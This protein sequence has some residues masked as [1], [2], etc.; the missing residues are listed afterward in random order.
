MNKSKNFSICL[1]TTGEQKKKEKKVG[2]ILLYK[3][4]ITNDLPILN[5][6]T[7]I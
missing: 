6:N 2:E 4:F 3:L 1:W 7:Q 5:L